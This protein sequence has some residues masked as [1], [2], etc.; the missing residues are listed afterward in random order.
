MNA[1]QAAV[2]ARTGNVAAV[3]DV[4]VV[5]HKGDSLLMLAAYHGQV[6]AVVDLLR[7]GARNTRNVRGLSSLDG[8]AFKGDVAVIE[9]IVAAGIDVNE[10]GPDGRTPLMWAAA[11][12]RTAAVERLLAA[13]ANANVVDNV[14]RA[15]VDHA[16]GMGAV[17]VVALLT[18]QMRSA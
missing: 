2:A 4:N 3:D 18:A 12:N 7:R 15:A 14:G 13:G 9:A 11:F 1:E 6:N 17:D 5:D 10:A 8:A 16:T